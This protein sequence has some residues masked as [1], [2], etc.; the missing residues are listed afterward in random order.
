MHLQYLSD[1]S[2]NHTAVVI[3][4]EQWK[5]L[6]KKYSDLQ[7]LESD[8]QNG[9]TAPKEYTMSDFMGTISPEA[10]EDLQTYTAKSRDEWERNS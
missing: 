5:A 1:Y 6:V 2:G 9:E 10:A 7:S 3:P 4:I 8:A